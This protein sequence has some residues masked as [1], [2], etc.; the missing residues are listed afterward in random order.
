M[1]IEVDY[2][3]HGTTCGSACSR[4]C[5]DEV[6]VELSFDILHC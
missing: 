6:V 5:E 1:R 2:S 4:F 3:G